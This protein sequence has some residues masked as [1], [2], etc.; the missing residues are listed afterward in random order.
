MYKHSKSLGALLKSN[1]FYIVIG[2][3]VAA[4]AAVCIIVAVNSANKQDNTSKPQST[5][6]SMVSAPVS[7]DETVSSEEPT[8]EPE[9]EP[10]PEIKLAVTNPTSKSFTTTDPNFTLSGSC[11]PL[12][13]LTLNGEKVKCDKNGFFSLEFKL[14]VGKNTFTLSHKEDTVTYTVNYRYVV[15]NSYS[16]SSKQTFDSGSVFG[17]SVKAREGASVKATFNGETINLTMKSIA[18]EKDSLFKTYNG[19]FKLPSDNKK[20]LNLGKVKF[21]ATQNGITETFKSGDIIC[22]KPVIPVIAEIVHFQAETFDAGST[23][24]WSSPL[25]NYL[26]KGTVD[27]VKGRAYYSSGSTKKEYAIL[28]YG[29]Q[30]YTSISD[31]PGGKKIA[32]IK[33]Y[34]GTLPDH[35]EI[36]LVSFSEEGKYTTFNFGCLFKAPFTFELLPQ[37]YKKPSIQDY[38]IS[39]VTATY[40]DITFCYATVFE[41]EISI[42][43][44]NP[45]FSSA[46]VIKEKG[47]YVLRLHLKKKGAFYGWDAFYNENDELVFKFLHP[48]VVTA[49]E[50]VCGADLTGVTIV[51]DAGHNG[52]G[53]D[54]GALGFKPDVYEADR[55]LVLARKIKE[56]LEAAGA[57]VIMTRD[58]EVSSITYQQRIEKLKNADADLCISV[59]HDSSTSSKANGYSVYYGTA[60]SYNASKA[61]LDT[62][63][64]A[65]IYS[66][67]RAFAWHYFFL[68]RTSNCPVVLTENGFM[69]N[70][71]DFAGIIDDAVNDKKADAIAKGIGNYFLSLK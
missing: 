4:L 54:T 2:V 19:S 32:I 1:L 62:T 16:P 21:T 71:D 28:R 27:Y 15:I 30:V 64:S 29:K 25:N 55:N 37:K 67:Q 33:E 49:A 48:T 26:P 58:S 22:K 9:P 10:E 11:D 20:D 69:S 6:S 46:E 44:E 18:A 17:V 41:G 65:N 42:S 36:K 61:I 66:K 43:A 70:K 12:F 57:T 13:D 40:V 68:A 50:N 51:V 56:R 34:E 14:E 7:S 23:N 35:N 60:F 52:V 24:D 39:S 45:L 63:K 5:P 31:N 59:H 53:K 8:P 38:S 3:I 47:Q